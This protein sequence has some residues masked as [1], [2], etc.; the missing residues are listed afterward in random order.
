MGLTERRGSRARQRFP[1]AVYGRGVEPD[2]RFSLANERTFLAW[3]R[4]SLALVAAGV[5]LEALEL[6]ILTGLRFVAAVVFIAL[7]LLAAAQAWVGWVR[8]EQALR[9]NRALPGPSSAAA[10][11][12][13][14]VLA[15]AVVAVGLFL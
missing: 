8:T 5:A 4:T 7:G 12:A 9:A 1:R 15:V 3:I 10:L 14:V 2:P 6:P 13:G 11:S